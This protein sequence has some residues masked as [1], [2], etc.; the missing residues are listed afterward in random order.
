MI[1]GFRILVSPTT[2]VKMPTVFS[3][4]AVWLGMDAGCGGDGVGWGLGFGVVKSHPFPQQPGLIILKAFGFLPFQT[5]VSLLS[6]N[7]KR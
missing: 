2:A 4:K 6:F 5:Y 3:P 1:S 7:L